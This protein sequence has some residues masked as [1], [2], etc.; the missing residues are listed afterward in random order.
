LES[1][2]GLAD[3]SGWWRLSV[4]EES[5]LATKHPRTR[6]AAAAEL[7]HYRQT[8]RFLKAAS[9]LPPGV[10]DQLAAATGTDS[11]DLEDWLWSSR[12]SRRH[13]AKILEFLGMRRLTR[14]DLADAFALAADELCPRGMTP[15]AL[16]DRLISWFFERK[17]E[18]PSEDELVRVTGGARRRFEERVLDAAGGLLPETLKAVLDASLADADPVTGFT[19]LKTDPGKAN[20]ENILT[21]AKRLEF[22]RSLALPAGLLAGGNDAVSRSFRRRVANETPWRMRQHPAG[23]RHALYALFLA[24]RE[25]EITDGLIDLLIE[26]VHRITSQAR[27]TVVKRIAKEVDKVE[28]KERILVRIAEAASANPDG[29]VRDVVF[30]VASLDTLSA[31]IREYKAAGTFERQ[32]HAVLRASYAGHY[33]RMLPAVLSALS[34]HSNNAVHRPVIEA[35]GWLKRFH[36]DGRRVVRLD[37]GVPIENVIP[38][39]WRDLVLEKDRQGNFQVNCINYEICVLTALRERLRCKEIWVAGAEKHRN[40]DEDLP[41][42][43]EERRA[44]YYRELGRDADARAFTTALKS[45]LTDALT[46]LNR[47]IPSNPKARILW[48]G[49]NR[50][51]ITPFEAL[52]PA[53]AADAIQAELE[54]RWPMT[55]LI[56][57][58][59]ET[60]ARTGFLDAFVTSGDRVILDPDTLK[61]R[62]LLC[63]YGLG[64]NAGLKRV[65]AGTD[66]VTHAELQH[67]R[68]L[69]VGKEALRSATAMVTN[70]ILAVRDT[71][72]W[73]EAGTACASDSKKVG[74][75]DQNL[76]TE[77]HVR[78]NGRGVMIYWHMERRAACIY[79]QLK[80][81][82]SSEVAAM[83]EGVLRHC[84]D[85]EIQ[86]HYVD[87]HGQSEVAFAFC[88]LL[89]FELAPRLKAV[90]RQ[91]LYLPDTGL[92][93]LLGD[94]APVLTRA[95]DWELI[96]R[97]YDEIIK[98]AAALRRG[99]ADPEAILRRFASTAVKHPTYAALAELGK[100]VKTIFLCR[101][102]EEEDFRREINAGLNVV[103]NWNGAQGFIF[104]GKSGE[105]AS[106]RLEDQ[107][108]SVLTLQLLQNCLIYVN[109]L[110]LQRIL[111]EPAWLERMT[112]EDHR[113]L[114]PAIHSHINPYGRLT[115]DLSRRID[116]EQRMAA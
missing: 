104:F 115:A 4:A 40:P 73:G 63:L 114:T 102:I 27:H 3:P 61:R 88:Y 112:P 71:R 30:P 77:W 78:Y 34:F 50:I 56:D 31:I 74:A 110:M 92:R 19:G 44:E 96:E 58:M 22:L 111:T 90:A 36:E 106:N 43:F 54:R 83:I 65:S 76:M 18:C 82:S 10:S 67:V 45:K 52:P 35:I 98:Y 37:E 5:F 86:R 12:T 113:A 14:R 51:S 93:D 69:F 79:S 72:I 8:G 59:T 49:K 26:T 32:V 42:D 17:I 99:T 97:Q 75:W 100:A 7:V 84:T 80:R 85:M 101:Y 47:T 16:M 46:R 20:L 25:R 55:E 38:P 70:A 13:R 48:R 105:I 39:K 57:V 62:L 68:R 109:T 95:I 91:K 23:R 107:E 6:L 2:L 21:A 28:G 41:V 116:F 60:A 15:G 66:G 9:D 11:D 24:H 33:R 94:L 103:E 64:T 89:N 108:L 53:P 1:E 81:C 87:S 29:T